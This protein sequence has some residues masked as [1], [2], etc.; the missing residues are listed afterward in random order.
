LLL[1]IRLNRWIRQFPQ[2]PWLP[3][4]PWFRR[5]KTRGMG[6][7]LIDPQKEI[8]KRG[9]AEVDIITRTAHAGWLYHRA[10]LSEE[11]KQRL[12]QHGA[13]TG[14]NLEWTGDAH[15]K[16]EKIQPGVPPTAMEKLDQKNTD[17][18]MEISGINESALGDL[19]RVQSGVAV[20][21]RQRQAV[22]AIQCY[23]D[24][25][26]RTKELG[27]VKLIEMFQNHYTE[28]RLIRNI[29]DDGQITFEKLNEILATG[30]IKNDITLGKYVVNIDETPLAASH[31]RAQT[32]ELKEMI[33]AGIIPIPAVQDVAIK[34][35]SIPQKETVLRR[36]Q[37]LQ[38]AAGIP[39]G[40]ELLT[41]GGAAQA[42]AAMATGAMPM[43]GGA[44]PM[45]PAK[46]GPNI[47][48]NVV[49]MPGKKESK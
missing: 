35:S 1:L 47:A 3:Y 16:P 5:G 12:E 43:P 19:D 39:M 15:Q 45:E 8:N 34:S 38:A 40:D 41:A 27:G 20:E 25:K 32:E 17:R 29:D 48:G 14:L 26:T 7:D 46:P 44:N 28:E 6:E 10:G 31:M 13:E 24:N 22:L 21:A 4:F 11:M 2:T 42:T 30:Q 23:M 37:A 9:S 36:V 49:P 18:L 33:E